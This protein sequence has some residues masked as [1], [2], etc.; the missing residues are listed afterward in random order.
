MIERKEL[1]SMPFYKK[2]YFTGSYLGMHYRIEKKSLEDTSCFFAT[3]F[4]GPYNF[5]TTDDAFMSS[6]S[7]DFSEEGLD[8]VCT[9]LNEKYLSDVDTWDKGTL[10]Y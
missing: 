6:E 3:V 7:F 2:T 10:I 5:E 4:P 9:W 8:N 1:F